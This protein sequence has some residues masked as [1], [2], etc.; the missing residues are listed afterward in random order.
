MSDLIILCA[1]LAI[2]VIL[3]ILY[4]IV[5]DWRLQRDQELEENLRRGF[6]KISWEG[7]PAAPS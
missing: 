6:E 2:T 7:I 3:A 4:G 5:I 1:Q